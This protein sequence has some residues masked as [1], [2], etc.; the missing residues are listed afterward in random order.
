[1]KQFFLKLRLW[2]FILASTFLSLSVSAKGKTLFKFDF[3][4][5]KVANGYL[6]VTPETYYTPS[7]G[8]GFIGD[9]E[10]KA[11][12]VE[13]GNNVKSD[14]CTS[15]QA[16]FF[17]VDIPEGNYTITLILGD[18]K[19]IS[20]TS[21]KVECR[22]LMLEQIET[23]NGQ[24]TQ[25]KISVH[26]RTPRISDTESVA[27]KPREKVYLHWDNQLTIE[28]TG[29]SPKVCGLE[30][31]ES[32][33]IPTMFIAGNSTVVDQA[34]EPWAAW[35]QMIPRFFQ[36][37]KI[38]VANY[39]ESG[40][41]IKSFDGE[42]RLAKV[43]GQMKTGDYLF[44]EFA[45]NDQ[46]PN[47]GLSAQ[48]TYKDY[49][50]KY[51]R[52][53]RDKGATPVLVTSMYRRRFDENGKIVN[54]LEDFPDAMRD[55]AKEE[56]VKLIDLNEMSKVFYEAMGVEES[57]KAFV[58]Y[59]ANTFTNQPNA[60]AD[61]T[62]FSNY[63]AY[64]LAKCVLEGII[65]ADLPCAKYIVSD[66]KNFDPAKP[67]SLESWNFPISPYIEFIKPDGN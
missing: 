30:I 7:L 12:K 44:I 1:M 47:S 3:G 53:T 23:V 42:R 65:K 16:F 38:V 25:E 4:T 45:H 66:Y 39:A 26:V 33:D 64:E 19:G 27:L 11:Q 35:G 24:T 40:E 28:F 37:E 41:T 20:N 18:K 14:F 59:P 2:T 61:D 62:H 51:I 50:R 8:Y 9:A 13:W 31:S 6:G 29:E 22:R 34:Y 57:K 32:S 48:T 58:H 67:D 49:L 46:K 63:G 5:S 55:I 21:V 52:M 56:N 43:M 54:S 60:L 36:G 15:K 10:I 17:T